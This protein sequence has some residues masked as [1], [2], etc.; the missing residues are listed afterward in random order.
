MWSLGVII[1]IMICGYP[2]FYSETPSK[3][4]SNKMKKKII[5]GANSHVS[6]T[7]RAQA[8]VNCTAVSQNQTVW[9]GIEVSCWNFV[10][11]RSAQPTQNRTWNRQKT[12]L[13]VCLTQR[14]FGLGFAL[15]AETE[16][17]GVRI[18]CEKE[19]TR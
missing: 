18:A 7:T 5:A 15:F 14:N 3:A 13:L 19:P 9:Q 12:N 8:R 1:Y 6:I 17:N 4:L 11:G 16:R 2:P 10:Q